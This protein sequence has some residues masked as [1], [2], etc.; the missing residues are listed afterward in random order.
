MDSSFCR[1][2]K[3]LEEDADD[4][5]E[6][7]SARRDGKDEPEWDGIISEWPVNQKLLYSGAILGVNFKMIRT[8]QIAPRSAL[9][10]T[11]PK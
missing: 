1:M 4:S 9:T 10:Q 2:P 11:E 8:D 5:E 7:P 6:Q 3:L